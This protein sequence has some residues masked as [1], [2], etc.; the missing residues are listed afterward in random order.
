MEFERRKR[1]HS[2]INVAPL[3]DIVFN[4]LLFF[5]ITYNV[6]TDPAIHVRLPESRTAEALSQEQ[7]VITLTREGQVYVGDDAVAVEGLVALLEPR[8]AETEEVSVKIKADD[9]ASVGVLIR[10]VDEVKLAG[11]NAFSIV[12]ESRKEDF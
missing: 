4:L 11:C 5:V 8:L 9:G 10:V 2:H 1:K 6:T 7:V 12:T 3:V